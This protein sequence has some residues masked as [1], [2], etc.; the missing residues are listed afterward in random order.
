[1]TCSGFRKI[2]GSSIR[3]SASRNLPRP[4]PGEAARPTCS[5]SL[6]GVRKLSHGNVLSVEADGIDHQRVALV[7]GR[8]THRTR[9]ASDFSEWGHVQIDTPHVVYRAARSFGLAAA[10]AQRTSVVAGVS[11]ERPGRRSPQHRAEREPHRLAGRAL[12]SLA[13]FSASFANSRQIGIVDVGDAKC[14]LPARYCWAHSGGR[15][16][17]VTGDGLP[18]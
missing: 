2:A 16:S 1:V 10:F 11:R 18:G 13:F 15:G 6:C 5:L 14:R 9:M 17:C 4:R 3:T 7:I 12:P 8:P